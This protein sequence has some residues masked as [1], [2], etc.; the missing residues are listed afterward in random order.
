MRRFLI[1]S[2]KFTGTAE[3]F[4]NKENV[5]VIIDCTDTDMGAETIIA[6][7]RAV[8]ATIEQLEQGGNFSAGTVV[9]EQG[10]RIPFE[11][12]WN[13]YEKKINKDRCV[14]LYAKLS[15]ADTV[16]NLYG[17][18]AYNKF[19]AKVKVRQKLDPENWLKNRSYQNDWR[20]AA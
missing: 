8:P 14:S 18:K 11:E 5:L 2:P 16:E 20:N 13:V 12:W 4:Y 1:T 15:D 7:K 6:F 9:L 10:Y 17:T 3:V 19:I